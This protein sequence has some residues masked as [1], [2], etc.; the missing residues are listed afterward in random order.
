MEEVE[1]MQSFIERVRAN[2]LKFMEGRYGTDQLGLGLIAVA[3]VFSLLGMFAWRWANI[4]SLVLLA[5]VI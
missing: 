1:T 5:V 4:V 2:V 3:L